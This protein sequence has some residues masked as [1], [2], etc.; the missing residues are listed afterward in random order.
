MAPPFQATERSEPLGALGVEGPALVVEFA[1]GDVGD[2]EG[3]R[4]GEHR[5]LGAEADAFERAGHKFL[6]PGVTRLQGQLSGDEGGGSGRVVFTNEQD[7]ASR[8]YAA[9]AEFHGLPPPG[10]EFVQHADLR[11][12]DFAQPV[13]GV[14]LQG[15]VQPV[16]LVEEP[17]HP[18]LIDVTGVFREDFGTRRFVEDPFG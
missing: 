16:A 17:H 14:Q 4:A 12:G 5:P 3:D 15:A 2:A 10:P 18:E 6:V 13:H 1:S 11:A 7:F 8:R 9:V